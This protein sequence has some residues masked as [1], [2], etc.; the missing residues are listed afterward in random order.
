[1][2]SHGGAI[3]NNLSKAA[4]DLLLLT[5]IT[6]TSQVNYERTKDKRVLKLCLKIERG[7][8]LH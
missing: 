2:E 4:E 6:S 5:N 8:K 7:E 1:M 3:G